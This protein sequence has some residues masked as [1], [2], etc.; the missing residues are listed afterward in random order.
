[1]KKLGYT[2]PLALGTDDTS[3]EKALQAY[4]A[5]DGAWLVLGGCGEPLIARPPPSASPGSG[6][7]SDLDCPPDILDMLKSQDVVRA[8]KVRVIIL[9][10]P[11]PKVSHFVC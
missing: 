1:M 6:S 4:Q 11:V 7:S 5:R 10:I 3:I 9:N 8:D 2:G